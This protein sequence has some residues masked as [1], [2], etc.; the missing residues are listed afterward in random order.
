MNDTDF[1]LIENYCNG[2]LKP[3]ELA[4]IELRMAKDR[5]FAEALK[6]RQSMDNLL[7]FQEKNKEIQ[8][9]LTQLGDQY[10]KESTKKE[11]KIVRVNRWRMLSAVA[12]IF[13]LLGVVTWLYQPNPTLY[14]QFAIHEP[15]HLVER[16]GEN[17]EILLKAEEIF[18][19]G[20]YEEAYQIFGRLLENSKNNSQYLIVYGIST[21]ELDK[22]E[23][24]KA[25]FTKIASGESAFKEEGKW[26]L[27]M[28]YLKE[29]DLGEVRSILKSISKNDLF[30]KNKVERLL[31]ALK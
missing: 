28:C 16:N 13:I 1:N 9:K 6:I 26:Y 27:A 29:G 4:E 7:L 10:F 2:T 5:E 31:K 17:A 18:N 14:E 24:A 23:E 30:W 11:I 21:L 22:L 15:I 12:A 8:P 20:D 3:N 25:I 19:R